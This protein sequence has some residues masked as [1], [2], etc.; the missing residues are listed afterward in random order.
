ME[1]RA[2]GGK[3]GPDDP[4]GGLDGSPE[5]DPVVVDLCY[6]LVRELVWRSTRKLLD[7]LVGNGCNGCSH[8]K[9]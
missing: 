5:H 8:E 6:E 7:G 2:Q 4:E 1:Y 9:S 3:A